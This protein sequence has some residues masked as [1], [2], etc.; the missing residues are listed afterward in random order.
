MLEQIC[1]TPNNPHKTLRL[2]RDEAITEGVGF[3]IFQWKAE[4]D[5][6][7]GVV[8]VNANCSRLKEI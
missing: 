5:P 1:P 7:K 2:I 6:S 8:I 3:F 4:L